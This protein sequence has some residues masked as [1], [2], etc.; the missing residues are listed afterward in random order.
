MSF[1]YWRTIQS[2]HILA[3][4]WPGGWLTPAEIPDHAPERLWRRLRR[5]VKYSKKTFIVSSERFASATFQARGVP[6]YVRRALRHIPVKIVIVIRPQADLAV[7][8]YKQLVRNQSIRPPFRAFVNA[9]PPQF[10]YQRLVRRWAAAFGAE[11]IIVLQYRHDGLIEEFLEAVG[12]PRAE[13]FAEPEQRRNVSVSVVSARVI[14]CLRLR[15]SNPAHRRKIK[16]IRFLFDWMPDIIP[17][18]RQRTKI[19]SHYATSNAAIGEMI[20]RR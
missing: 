2:Q 8:M 16:W 20:H 6:H 13:A 11:N 18:R 15:Q 14:A 10:D 12:C 17:T 7:A 4:V 3:H 1:D 5:D 19:E 9:L